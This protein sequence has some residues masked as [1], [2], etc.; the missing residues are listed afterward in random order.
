M[1][2]QDIHDRFEELEAGRIQGNLSVGEQ[3]EWQELSEAHGFGS[4]FSLELTAAAIEAEF[5]ASGPE[6]LP[7]DLAAA[8]RNGMVRST[9]HATTTPETIAF[10]LWKR[11]YHSPQAAWSLAALFALL[12]VATFIT[13]NP[14]ADTGSTVE[15]DSVSPPEARNLLITK[16]NDVIESDFGG[17][18][19]FSGM[20]GKVVWSDTLQ[21]GYMTLTNLPANDPSVNQY[22]LWMVDPSRDEKPV[23]GGVFDI[24]P[25]ESTAVVPIRNPLSVKNPQA[26]V[27][28]LEQPGGV[29]VS[30]QETVVALAKA[31]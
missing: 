20:T 14:G 27:I 25:G 30:K 6:R 26:F 31:S 28:T 7:S 22:Q 13:R 21:E 5:L 16:A 9:G 23:D 1:S 24:P 12:L 15:R 2:E 19:N 18:E 3:Q 10:P 29:V 8:I 17:T 4:D 11:I